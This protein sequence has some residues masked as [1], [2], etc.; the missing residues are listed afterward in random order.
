MTAG[1]GFREE[2]QNFKRG[3]TIGVV[4][5]LIAQFILFFIVALFKFFRKKEKITEDNVATNN[6]NNVDN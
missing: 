5:T 1:R 6:T 2:K 3:I 4:S